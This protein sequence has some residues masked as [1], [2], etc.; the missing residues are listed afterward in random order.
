MMEDRRMV[1]VAQTILSAQVF[2]NSRSGRRQDSFRKK[3]EMKN[4]RLR[5]I[6]PERSHA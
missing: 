2:S 4:R 1:F 6:K 3:R 5:Y